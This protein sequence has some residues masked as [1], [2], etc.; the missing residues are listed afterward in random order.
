MMQII[1]SP[2]EFFGFTPGDDREMARWD[3][4]VSYFERLQGESDCILVENM[5]PTTEGNPFLAVTISSAENLANLDT[6]KEISRKIADPRA[7]SDAQIDELIEKGKAVCLQTMSMHANEI[8]GT[9]MSIGLAY[10]LL[11]KD[12]ADTRRILDNVIFVLVPCFNPDG[13]I[14]MTDWYYK[15]KGTEYEGSDDPDIF[16]KYAGHDNNRDAVFQNIPE[17]RYVSKLLYFDWMPQTYL[18]HHHMGSYGARQELIPF[19]NPLRPDVDPIIWRELAFYGAAMARRDEIEGLAGVSSGGVYPAWAHFGFHY[20]ANSHN[21]VGMLTETACAKLAT[22]KYVD[23]TQ[24]LQTPLLSAPHSSYPNPWKGGWWRLCDIV[25]LQYNAAYALLDAMARDKENVLRSMAQK[26][27]N[28]TARGKASEA[29]AYIIPQAQHD[30]SEFL[31]LLR[32]LRMQNIELHAAKS[33]FT[34]GSTVYP[35]GTYV[36]FL[37]QPKYGVI[38]NLLGQTAFPNNQWTRNDAGVVTG[39]D[40]FTD[41]VNEFLGVTVLPANARFD[42]DFEIV[43]EITDAPKLPQSGKL[44]LDARENTA[45][46]TVNRLLAAGYSVWRDMD[47]ENHDFYVEGEQER[48]A[49]ILQAAP[50]LCRAAESTPKNLL[51][52]RSMKIGVYR[53]Y[54]FGNTTEGWTRYVLDRNGFSYTSLYDK[55]ILENLSQYDVLVISADFIAFLLGLDEC[56]KSSIHGFIRWML[57]FGGKQPKEY[58]SGFGMAGVRAIRK[59]VENGGRLIAEEKTS[60]FAINYLGLSV[61]NIVLSKKGT[62]YNTHGSTLRVKVDP[63]NPLAYGMPREILLLNYNSPVFKI[64][65]WFDADQFEVPVRYAEKDLLRSG[66]LVGED[67]LKNQGALVRVKLGK[68]E[69]ILYGF[70]PHWRAQTGG[71]FKLFFNALYQ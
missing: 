2:K 36:V 28:Q 42:G 5:G 6:Y 49:Q 24:L 27:K 21:I 51:P 35:A 12:D 71:V 31:H 7:L 1:T 20:I 14:Q 18:D 59:F 30:H 29:Y 45:Y 47:S 56:P 50:T 54:Y 41:T 69:V 66:Y 34:V 67:L 16:H 3:K 60:N 68:G 58:Q 10:D 17:S 22:P 9:Q 13:Q 4:I 46:L 53:R 33:L 70:E 39:Y 57:E 63:A 19:K 32:L 48:L 65:D 40:S 8:G 62:E 44:I 52:V 15:T 38:T 64:T 37:A 25:K 11:T 23:P 26:A 61:E 55:D 43:R